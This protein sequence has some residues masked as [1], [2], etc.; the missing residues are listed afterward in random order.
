MS[1]SLYYLVAT[2]IHI[3]SVRSQMCVCVY[4]NTCSSQYR[5]AGTGTAKEIQIIGTAVNVACQRTL[6]FWAH[7]T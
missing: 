6:A 1:H 2:V 4:I 3:Q 7:V 5:D